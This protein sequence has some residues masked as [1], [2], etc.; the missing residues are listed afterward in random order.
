M[1]EVHWDVQWSRAKKKWKVTKH[2]PQ[3]KRTENIRKTK[4][5]AVN[6]A[7]GL[8]TTYLR[9]TEDYT[10]SAEVHIYQKGGRTPE[11]IKKVTM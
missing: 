5:A 9:R 6:K 4:K 7:E 1:T 10:Y 3:G 8:A 11:K 2:G